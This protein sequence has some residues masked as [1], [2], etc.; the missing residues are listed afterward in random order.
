M[1]GLYVHI[2][3]C[4]QKCNYC[5]FVSF[6][7]TRMQYESYIDILCKEMSKYKGEE[8]DTIFIGGGT[9][10][11]LPPTL[12]EKLLFC[13][14]KTFSVHKSCEFSIEANPKTLDLEKISIMKEFNVNRVS[15]G[16]QSFCDD[17]LLM[18]GRIHTAQDAYNTICDLKNAGFEN[19]NIDIMFSLP[20]QTKAIFESTLNRAI[21]LQVPHISCYSLIV[22]PNT[23]FYTQHQQN[24]LNLPTDEEDRNFYEMAQD[25]FQRHGYG[26][27][28]ISNFAKSGYECRHNIKYW[29]CEEYI[30][31]GLNAHSYIGNERFSNTASLNEYMK[32]NFGTGEC[33]VL[34][35][36]D[37]M[38]E[39]MIMGLRMTCGISILEFK[40]RFG[41][42]IYEVYGKIIEKFVK[43]NL[44]N[45]EKNQI[46]LSQAGIHISNIVLCEF[47]L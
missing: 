35:Q 6:A 34:F 25:V 29:R 27:Y 45:V 44:L 5:D 31:V 23:L 32:E 4:V 39:F 30:G 43:L 11:V 3:F 40:K 46:Y 21:S 28:E 7:N 8:V 13:I 33:E 17:Q 47:I 38:F 1:K 26:Q 41:K 22:E 12:L 14:K 36:K 10:T 42:D 16:V 9:P 19:I 18:L 20:D 24:Q 2:P 37:K 15:V